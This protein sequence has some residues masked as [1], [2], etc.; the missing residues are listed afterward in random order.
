MEPVALLEVYALLMRLRAN[1]WPMAD[2]AGSSYRLPL[3]LSVELT[4]YQLENVDSA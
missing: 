2:Y 3:Q 1:C 4:I